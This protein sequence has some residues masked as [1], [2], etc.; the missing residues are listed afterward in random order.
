MA[1]MKILHIIPAPSGGVHTVADALTNELCL[2]GNDVFLAD[3]AQEI[4]HGISYASCLPLRTLNV[5]DPI[6]S[7]STAFLNAFPLKEFFRMTN[8]DIILTHGPN[9]ILRDLI[10][11]RN[12][13]VLTVSHGTYKNEI[14]WMK[15]HPID[16]V[17]KA[18]YLASIRLSFMY[19]NLTL[20]HASI[21]N[22]LI[23]AISRK[24]SKELV[25]AGL[26]FDKI[27]IILNGVD[28][29]K[30]RPIDK[31]ISRT[32][33]EQKLNILLKEFVIVSVGV[34][35]LKGSHTLVLALA[36]LKKQNPSLRFSAFLIGRPSSSFRFVLQSLINHFGLSDNVTLV[37]NVNHSNLS[38]FYNASD[39]VVSPSYSEGGPLTVAESL[40]CGIPT[41]AT[42]VG[43]SS[44]FLELSGLSQMLVE[45]KQYNFSDIL[46]E[47]INQFIGQELKPKIESIPDWTIITKSYLRVMHELTE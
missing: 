34:A 18:R 33:V 5:A 27:R 17:E 2:L 4:R 24:T 31:T 16:G 22:G 42:D 13:P 28:K 30:F 11:N 41:I 35:P 29:T 8:P 21:S 12:F 6:Y 47:R 39:L 25:Q 38:F 40:A 37:E 10:T 7:L 43:A 9:A 26:P 32:F 19:E 36:K 45:I 14:R 46:A 1:S 23:V 44:E 20:K 3:R 15:H